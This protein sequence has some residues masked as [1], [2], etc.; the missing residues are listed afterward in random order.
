MLL[1]FTGGALGVSLG[2][3]I[4]VFL[5]RSAAP[6]LGLAILVGVGVTR[7]VGILAALYPAYQAARM[8]PAE[9]V[10]YE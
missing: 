5:Y 3:L 1:G 9:A 6:G 7:L 4:F 10:R 8:L 2:G